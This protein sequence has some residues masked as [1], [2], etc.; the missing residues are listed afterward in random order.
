MDG[1]EKLI[2]PDLWGK[3]LADFLREG[4]R[5]QRFE[6]QKPIAEDWGWSIPVVN[7]SFRLWI[8][9]G[10]YQEY[11]DGF[12][13]FI[14]AHKPLV[15]RFFKRVDTR[16][17]IT[18]LR[19]AL[20][21]VLAEEEGIRSKR[22]WTYEEFNHPSLD[23]MSL[24]QARRVLID[25]IDSAAYKESGSSLSDSDKNRLFAAE[26]YRS[27]RDVVAPSPWAEGDFE[28]K[29]AGLMR[30]ANAIN[31]SDT[32]FGQAQKLLEAEDSILGRV[33]R[34]SQTT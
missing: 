28:T 8:G 18:A 4:L 25:G 31:R 34:R 9:C 15:W 7:R 29:M 6:T 16:H 2:N 14:E 1:E 11:D 13:C 26:E 21:R 20:D 24:E 22:W 3:R 19:E 17:R 32:A 10:H 27:G 12:L 23:R 5:K 33:I 30:S